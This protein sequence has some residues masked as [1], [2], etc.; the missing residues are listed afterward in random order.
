MSLAKSPPVAVTLAVKAIVVPV[1]VR[2][3]RRRRIVTVTTRQAMRV[4]LE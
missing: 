4:K 2:R 3:R 1:Q